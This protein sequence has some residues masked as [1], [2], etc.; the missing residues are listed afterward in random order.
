MTQN[1]HAEALYAWNHPTKGTLY[2]RCGGRRD[3]D[4]TAGVRLRGS[5]Q[6]VSELARVRIE[7]EQRL[8]QHR[9]ENARLA[10]RHGPVCPSAEGNHPKKEVPIKPRAK[11]PRLRSVFIR[12]PQ[13]QLLLGG[14]KKELSLRTSAHA[15]VA[16][17][18]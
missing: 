8:E 6:D 17:P 5:H 3:P 2:I 15:G 14:L 9:Q 13:I 4:Y 7:V 18:G 11:P 16:I 10:H 1:R 12:Q